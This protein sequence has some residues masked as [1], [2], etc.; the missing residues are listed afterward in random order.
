MRGVLIA[1]GLLMVGAVV[2]MAVTAK[3]G[4]RDPRMHP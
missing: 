3:R 1:W 2:W 4:S